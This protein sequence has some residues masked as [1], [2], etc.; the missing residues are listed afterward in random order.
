MKKLLPVLISGAILS[1]SNVSSVHAADLLSVYRDA[2]AYDAQFAAARAALEAGRERLPQGRAGLLP[3][4]GLGASTTWN[5]VETRIQTAGTPTNNAKYNTNGWSVN[6]TQPLFRW[7]NW[8]SYNQAE[9]SV[10]LS[11]AQYEAAQ[12]D[13]MVR[14]AQTYFDVLVAQDALAT[15]QTRKGAVA[16]Q[17]ESAKRNF[18]VGTTTITDQHEAQALY[19]IVVAQ[20]LLAQNDLSVKQH[21][22][23]SLIGK[24]PQGLK[25][26]K[27]GVALQSPVPADMGKWV[28]MAETA[29]PGV[30][31]AQAAF[32]IA[33][34]EVERSYAG[35]LPTLD[36]VATRSFGAQGYNSGLGGAGVENESST[37]GLQLSMPLFAGGYTQS[38]AREA[39]SLK[40][41]AS[42]D[43]D[44]AKRSAALVARQA[45]LGVTSGLALVKAYDASLTSSQSALASNKLGYEVGVRINIDVLNA[46]TQLFDT[47]QKLSKSRV[48]TLLAL[49]RLKAATGSL[50][51][52]DLASINA[53]L[54]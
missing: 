7:Q 9:L 34:R 24:D 54:D 1:L 43:L 2:L 8:V 5:D 26:L 44:N 20:E 47:Q 17:L 32:Q 3:T 45:Y 41:K 21:A 12:M 13:L 35:H 39:V 22:M 4:L 27:P 40:T 11:E 38:K 18:E 25:R 49:L 16:E 53:L 30:R 51:D 29:A 6:L 23:Q 28:E 15:A 36:I 42:A 48:D 50:V 46:Q 33:D 10:A 52:Q 19:D 31:V 14:A 37:V